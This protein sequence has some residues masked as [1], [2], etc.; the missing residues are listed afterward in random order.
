[1]HLQRT[2]GVGESGICGYYRYTVTRIYP[3]AQ[4]LLADLLRV[5]GVGHDK[6]PVDA[7]TAA[8]CGRRELVLAGRRLWPSCVAVVVVVAEVI[9]LEAVVA[10]LGSG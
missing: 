2:V 6:G 7:T 10:R 5:R 8:E 4:H 1:M 9:V 3:I